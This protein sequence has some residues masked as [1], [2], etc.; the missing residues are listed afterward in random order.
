MR[1]REPGPRF[2]VPFP[3]R[4]GRAL[5]LLALLVS[6]PAVAGS[7]RSVNGLGQPMA[8]PAGSVTYHPDLGPLGGLSNA[9]A[10]ALLTGAFGEWASLGI[11]TFT[12]GPL[13]ADDIN[14]ADIPA[15]NAAHYK[16]LWRV[17]GDGLSPVIFDTDGAIIDDLF[18][19]DARLDIL[20]IA[21]LDTPI[22]ATPTIFEASI[23]ING[24]FVDG[25][26]LPTSPRTS[27]P[28]RRSRR[29]WSTRSGT[30]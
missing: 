19:E 24:A 2:G 28:R 1:R 12:E 26:G 23:I 10:R 14:A 3:A 21:A 18:G 30:S 20:G 8:W 17:D 16:H 29:S 4:L 15:T 5:G 27:P 9:Q 6:L 11:L 13:L 25:I 7:P 22:S